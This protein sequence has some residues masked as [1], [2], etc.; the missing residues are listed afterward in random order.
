MTLSDIL[1]IAVLLIA[2]PINWYVTFRLLRLVWMS[3]DIQILRERA[4]VA[5]GLSVL[6]TVFA[7]VFAN[8]DLDMPV[9]DAEGTRLVTRTAMLAVSTFTAGY[10]LAVVRSIARKKEQDEGDGL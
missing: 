4:T 3:P 8:N 1:T 2:L 9:L 5:G 7:L 6:I 10:W